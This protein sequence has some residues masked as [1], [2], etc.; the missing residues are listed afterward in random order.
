MIQQ[1]RVS[2]IQS[3]ILPLAQLLCSSLLLLLL[4]LHFAHLCVIYVHKLVGGFNRMY[5]FILVVYH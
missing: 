4:L 1:V 5:N 2:A 3:A